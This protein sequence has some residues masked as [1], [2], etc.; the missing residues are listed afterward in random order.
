MLWNAVLAAKIYD[1]QL[2]NLQTYSKYLR[3]LTEEFSMQNICKIS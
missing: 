1:S 3:Y 2:R